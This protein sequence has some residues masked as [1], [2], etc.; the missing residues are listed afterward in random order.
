MKG[1]FNI[2]FKDEEF[3]GLKFRSGH[4]N[5]GDYYDQLFEEGSH[6]SEVKFADSMDEDTME[7]IHIKLSY[8]L[9]LRLISVVLLVAAIGFVVLRLLWPALIILLGS[10]A[11][12][13]LNV[14]FTRKAN[15]LYALREGTRGLVSLGFA[16]RQK[17]IDEENQG[18]EGNKKQKGEK[19]PD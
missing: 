10:A 16:Q 4:K 7:R 8:S 17:E 6:Y 12:F 2:G 5:T 19:N 18:N 11:L 3:D 15:E 1:L 13:L 9:L 14:L